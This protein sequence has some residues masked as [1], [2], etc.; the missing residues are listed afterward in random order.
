MVMAHSQVSQVS[1][2]I[3]LDTLQQ[4]LAIIR[5]MVRMVALKKSNGFYLYGRGGTSKT[6][7]V[8]ETL[9][10]MKVPHRYESAHLTPIGLFDELEKYPNYVFILD[11]VGGLLH[12]PTALNF[13][14]AAL[15]NQSYGNGERI[16]TYQKSGTDRRVIFTGG[17]IL[18][19]NI[20]MHD[21]PV[22]DALKSRVN[23]LKYDP[24][25]EEIIALMRSITADGW[26]KDDSD[27]T[28]VECKELV[29][30]IETESK[31]LGVRPDMRM[32]CDKGLPFIQA[33]NEGTVKEVHW[34]DK[35]RACLEG[36]VTDLR[37]TLPPRMSKLDR[38][39]QNLAVLGKIVS[40]HPDSTTDE[41]LAMWQR[42][43]G[44][45]RS[46]FFRLKE[47][48]PSPT[49]LISPTSLTAS[50]MRLTFTDATDMTGTLD[51]TIA[52]GG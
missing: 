17:I 26:D 34:K 12:Q 36:R 6:F 42:A 2:P 19:S 13:L 39:N 10:K 44:G 11:D 46:T 51:S 30:F 21:G 49:S 27:I 20:A 40:E 28:A 23:P 15:G 5:D 3:P 9:E 14:L 41:H 18:I 8:R 25:D 52:V 16:V 38:R 32:L 22:F 7:V 45:S 33:W 47:R 43:T 35:V 4:R 48:F 37:H 50:P 24:T 1:E 29:D 31:K